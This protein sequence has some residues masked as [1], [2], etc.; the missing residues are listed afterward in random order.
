MDKNQ[1]E[2]KKYFYEGR[3]IEE[4]ELLD[5]LKKSSSV[6]RIA[7][8]I[9]LLEAG[10]SVL[11]VGCHTGYFTVRIAEKYKKVIGIDILPNNIEIAN[12]FFNRPNIEYK[13]MDALDIATNFREET[14]NCIVITEVLEHIADPDL[15][16]KN[17]YKLLKPGGILIISTP[18]AYSF[19]SFMDYFTIINLVRVVKQ[20]ENQKMG[21]GTNVDHVFN[22]DIFSLSRLFIINGFKIKEFCFAGAYLPNFISYIFRRIL[23][24]EPPEP[25]WILPILGRFAYQIIIKFSKP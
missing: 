11:D 21:I 8:T 20:L 4:K 17:C 5:T 24:K 19:K 13:V 1:I 6:S 7:K 9:K 22:W 18:N 16:I 2:N 25:K 15:L 23:K 10:D 12:K 14:F 3:W